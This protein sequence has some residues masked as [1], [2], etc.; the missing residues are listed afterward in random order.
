MHHITYRIEYFGKIEDL[1]DHPDDGDDVDQV[2]DIAP[3]RH[4]LQ[5]GSNGEKRA[6]AGGQGRRVST[7]PMGRYYW[8]NPLGHV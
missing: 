2:G 1:K 8:R 5:H 4:G 3:P 7:G 6:V